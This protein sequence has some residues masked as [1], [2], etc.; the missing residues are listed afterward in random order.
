M[1]VA[2]VASLIVTVAMFAWLMDRKDQRLVAEHA[3]HRREVSDLLQRIQ[4]P[5]R[6]VMAHDDD[7]PTPAAALDLENDDAYW[8]QQEA[9]RE[10]AEFEKRLA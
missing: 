4:A 3:A 1:T 2:L 6:A 8:T 5:E 10:A 7:M 9:L